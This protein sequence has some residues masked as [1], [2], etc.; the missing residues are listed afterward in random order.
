MGSLVFSGIR[1]LV[2]WRDF[3]AGGRLGNFFA[4]R[5]VGM[6]GFLLYR[7]QIDIEC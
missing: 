6:C 4:W 2:I 5:A 7:D 1:R 3:V